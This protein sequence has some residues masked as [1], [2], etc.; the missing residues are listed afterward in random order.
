MAHDSSLINKNYNE[1]IY[2]HY[3]GK[4][5]TA[6]YSYNKYRGQILQIIELRI[7]KLSP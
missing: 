2:W 7:F 1:I 6:C 3:N 5:A 4:T